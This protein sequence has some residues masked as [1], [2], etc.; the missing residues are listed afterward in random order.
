MRWNGIEGKGDA[1]E[2]PSSWEIKV[3]VAGEHVENI[4]SYSRRDMES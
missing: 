1:L 3:Q 4:Q 2:S